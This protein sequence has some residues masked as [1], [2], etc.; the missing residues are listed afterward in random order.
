MLCLQFPILSL[1]E[2]I[3][4]TQKWLMAFVKLRDNYHLNH[5]ILDRYEYDNKLTSHTNLLRS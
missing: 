2:R 4:F 1:G 5:K 3:E